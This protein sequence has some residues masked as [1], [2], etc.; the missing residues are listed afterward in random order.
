ML[1]TKSD[2]PL[3][4]HQKILNSLTYGFSGRFCPRKW[5]IAPPNFILM[6]NVSKCIL[7]YTLIYYLLKHRNL[8]CDFSCKKKLPKFIIYNNKFGLFCFKNWICC[9]KTLR[10]GADNSFFQMR[11]GHFL[12]IWLI[13]H[14]LTHYLQWWLR[15][16]D[17]LGFIDLFM[18][19]LNS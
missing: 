18:W 15:Q 16:K 17:K 10:Q 2:L 4:C 6:E 8:C 7:R 13:S 12:L 9:F 11:N 14:L 1:R 19:H 3:V 5:K